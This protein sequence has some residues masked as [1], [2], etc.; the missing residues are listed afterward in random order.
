MKF[1][2]AFA[3][4]GAARAQTVPIDVSFTLLDMKDPYNPPYPPLAGETVRLVLGE[5][6]DWQNPD[7]GH[8]FVTD[9]KGEA[10]FTMNGLL[11]PVWRWRNI[12]FTPLSMPVKGEHMK[13]GVELLHTI[14]VEGGSD[15]TARWL[16]T[17]DLDGF[18][19]QSATV[20]FM[21][22]YTPDA[23]G[24]FTKALVRQGSNEAWK[25]PAM[26]DKIMWGMSYEVA[27]FLLSPDPNDPKKRTLQYGF[28]RRARPPK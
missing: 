7:A 3:L 10:H 14:P 6:P 23:Q 2:M 16:L 17:M 13:I 19:G 11:D 26:N 20:G 27:N 4:L 25:V 22:I 9:E 18:K 24:R 12:G 8:K 15:F 1:L 21:G 28:K 5:T